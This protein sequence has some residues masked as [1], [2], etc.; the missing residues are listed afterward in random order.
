MG[1][2]VCLKIK[3]PEF[4]EL[5]CSI[6]ISEGPTKLNSEKSGYMLTLRDLR[7]VYPCR[8]NLNGFLHAKFSFF[9]ILHKYTY[10]Y[11]ST[12]FLLTQFLFEDNK[13]YPQG[14]SLVGFYNYL[15]T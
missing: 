10:V 15:I 11:L 3:S 6:V 13:N 7:T 1:I 5:G 2:L 9:K 4:G 14:Q 8:N 12:T